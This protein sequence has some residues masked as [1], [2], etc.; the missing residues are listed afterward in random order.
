MSILHRILLLVVFSIS[1]MTMS[2]QTVYLHL[3][4][5][6][7]RH[8]Y[9]VWC[10]F[11]ESNLLCVCS[12]VLLVPA[13]RRYITCTDS[14]SLPTLVT[15]PNHVSLLDRILSITVFYCSRCRCIAS[16]LTPFWSIRPISVFFSQLIPLTKIFSPSFRKHQQYI[17]IYTVTLEIRGYY[18][19]FCKLAKL[20]LLKVGYKN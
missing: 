10:S 1:S 12:P 2:L 7:A 17:Q 13:I 8:I 19:F 14:L 18:R 4:L 15:C 16:F 6:F 9:L 3:D 5:S 11:W 20:Q